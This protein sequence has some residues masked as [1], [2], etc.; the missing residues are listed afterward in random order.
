[1]W[2]GPPD[3]NLSGSILAG[4]LLLSAGWAWAAGPDF[5]DWRTPQTKETIR[6]RVPLP[7]TVMSPDGTWYI[8]V[9]APDYLRKDSLVWLDVLANPILSAAMWPV[10]K[11]ASFL[12]RHTLSSIEGAALYAEREEIIERGVQL[13]SL[14]SSGRMKAY[15]T[16]V[17]DGGTGSRL[18]AAFLYRGLF[19]GQGALRVGGALTLGRDWYASTNLTGPSYTPWSLTPRFAVSAARSGEQAIYVPGA[20]GLGSGLPPQVVWESRRNLELGLSV[21]IG[22]YGGLE[23]TFRLAQREIRDPVRRILARD[24]LPESPWL[25]DGDRG[26]LG[27]DETSVLAGLLWGR[28]NVNFEGTPSEGGTQGMALLRSWNRGGGDAVILHLDFTRYLLLG[29]EKYGYRKGDLDAYKDLSPKAIVALLDPDLLRKRLTQRRILAL[30]FSARRLWELDPK[31]DPV[32]YFH[33][34][35]LGGDAPARA[36]G[37][38]RLMDQAVIGGTAEY[39]WPI[40]RFIDGSMFL[41]LAWAG[42]QWWE[43][44]ATGLAPGTGFGLRVRTPTMFLFRG[45]FAYGLEGPRM[46]LTVSPEF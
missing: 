38:R 2:H 36:Y 19:D 42:D 9:S 20:I 21:P 44:N 34:P 30:Q 39:R 14:D 45:Q 41:E 4:A 15:P 7:D 12:S 22:P 43:P 37:G 8:V 28:G 16:I 18:G 11:A 1:M 10:E 32:S 27:G 31:D 29:N 23:P 5:P 40:W 13:V 26:I 24:S 6:W 17:M 33:F 35:S 46:I 3:V 25:A